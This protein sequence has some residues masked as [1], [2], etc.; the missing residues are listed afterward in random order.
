VVFEPRLSYRSG[1]TL[2]V[3]EIANRFNPVIY[4]LEYDKQMAFPGYREHDIRVIKPNLLESN[5]IFRSF[6]KNRHDAGPVT[7]ASYINF[8]KMKIDHDYDVLNPHGVPSEWIRNRNRRVCWYCHTPSRLAFDLHDFS[9]KKFNPVQRLA[10]EPQLALFRLID[11]HIA[12]KIEKICVNSSNTKERVSKYLHRPDAEIVRPGITPERFSC[13]SYEKFFFYPSRMVPEKRIEYTIEAF[14]KFSR[15]NKTKDW[16]LIISGYV[17]NKQ[18]EA[19]LRHLA[20]ISK[21]SNISFAKN[22]SN[23]EFSG[24]YSN[25]YSVLFSAMNEDWGNIPLE[26][27][28][29]SKPVISVNEGGPRESIV[30]GK[31]GY[32]V[33]STDEMADRMIY[34]ADH[35]DICEQMGKAGRKRVE[36]NY[37]WKIFLDRMEK[38]F[39]ETAKM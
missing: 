29:S 34:L 9:I 18:E 36:Q 17:Q 38:A 24:F 26:G 39:K 5:A 15:S 33:N 25:C 10:M 22:P 16:K 37:T 21:G 35:P 3:L 2:N 13:E 6:A 23:S 11:R 32:L 30:D 7:G 31:T 19:Y 1:G 4:T 8:L 14:K 28:A 20:V 12:K 27:M